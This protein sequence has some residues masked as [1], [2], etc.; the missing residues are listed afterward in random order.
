MK[1]KIL[2][3][4]APIIAA[5]AFAAHTQPAHG[6]GPHEGGPPMA[7]MK[8][9]HEAMMAQRIADMKTVL[10]LRSDQESALAALMATQRPKPMMMG[11]HPGVSGPRAAQSTPE[12]LADMAKRDA[13][14]SATRNTQ[15]EAMAKF[16]AVLT[17]DQQKVFDALSRLQHGGRE[18]GP[19]GMMVRKIMIHGGPDGPMP[20]AP[21]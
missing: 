13:E 2:I 15:R 19:G 4:A 17:P 16:Y 6:P 7:E 5:L 12:R 11:G 8:A 9:M 21:H 14:M 10:K 18:G 3:A 1:T 20:G